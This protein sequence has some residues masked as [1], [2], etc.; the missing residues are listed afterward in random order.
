MTERIR[1]VA[2]AR[3]LGFTDVYAGDLHAGDVIRTYRPDDSSVDETVVKVT[4]DHRTV[5][6]STKAG[7][8]RYRHRWPTATR[9]EVV[10]FDNEVDE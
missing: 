8:H 3:T 7:A 10:R 5:L 6:V 9:V 2:K 4:T 1:R